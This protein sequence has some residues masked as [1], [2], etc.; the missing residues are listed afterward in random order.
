MSEGEVFLSNVHDEEMSLLS[1]QWKTARVG[2]RAYD[3]AN[4]PIADAAL[5]PVFVS[6]EEYKQRWGIL[7]RTGV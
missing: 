1:R 4:C 2:I 7:P 6:P 5:K 3:I